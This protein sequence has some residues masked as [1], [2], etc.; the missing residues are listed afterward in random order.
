MARKRS[1]GATRTKIV[2]ARL[3]EVTYDKLGDEAQR[4][5]LSRAAYVE[6]LIENKA[7]KVVGG[8]ADTL[9]T[10]VINELKRVGNNLNQIAHARNAGG[11]VDPKY[12]RT[13]LSEIIAVMCSNEALKRRYD[14]AE[15]QINGSKEAKAAE[16]PLM[17]PP[18][19][20]G[21]KPKA[22]EAPVPLN[23]A[24]RAAESKRSPH[25]EQQPR[26][27]V[28]EIA[29][30]RRELYTAQQQGRRD[31]YAAEQRAE[32]A[33]YAAEQRVQRAT[34]QAEKEARAGAAR[35]G[36]TL[37]PPVIHAPP[38]TAESKTKEEHSGPPPAQTWQKLSWRLFLR[39][40]RR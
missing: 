14:D 38:R 24:H 32:R 23:E 1:D 21:G 22:A 26:N 4:H 28:D 10:V 37:R 35:V 15:R 27:S 31:V 19:L 6:H 5:G 7:I 11:T 13:V 3:T 12:C 34:A 33:V 39:P 9:P 25:L 16:V 17:P 36:M 2:S 40:S 20:L 18:S 29:H 30:T 8:P